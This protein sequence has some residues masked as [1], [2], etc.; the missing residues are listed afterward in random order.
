MEARKQDDSYRPKE[1]A[2]ISRVGQFGIIGPG[3]RED[4]VGTRVECIGG[5]EL[6]QDRGLTFWDDENMETYQMFNAG[7]IITWEARA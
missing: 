5:G 3:Y 2:I 7:D 1:E 4:L 6:A